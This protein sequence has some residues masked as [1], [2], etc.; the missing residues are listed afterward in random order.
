MPPI[1]KIDGKGRTPLAAQMSG[2]TSLG[3]TDARVPP[4]RIKK[5]MVVPMAT[6]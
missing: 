3:V 6:Q 2:E 5:K 1:E 4:A